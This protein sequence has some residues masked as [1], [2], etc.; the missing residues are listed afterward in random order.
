MELVAFLITIYALTNNKSGVVVNKHIEI[1]KI[2]P[3][4]K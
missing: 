4:E 3:V 2:P 1:G